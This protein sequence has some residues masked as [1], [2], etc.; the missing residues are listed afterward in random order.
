MDEP[1]VFASQNI[2][3]PKINSGILDKRSWCVWINISVCYSKSLA[4]S[5]PTH[6][7]QSILVLL[8]IKILLICFKWPCLLNSNP[9]LT[10][11]FS[12]LPLKHTNFFNEK[13][14]LT[15]QSKSY[16]HSK[17]PAKSSAVFCIE[18]WNN[19]SEGCPDE[20]EACLGE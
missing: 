14:T 13:R 15:R 19:L 18:V 8:K 9:T 16:L 11:L 4:P 7:S 12:T 1:Y 5:R 6:L 10:F 3:L 17:Y 2:L 20:R